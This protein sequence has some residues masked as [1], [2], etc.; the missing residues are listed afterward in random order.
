VLHL[1]A[2]LRSEAEGGEAA[3]S[4]FD[5][6]TGLIFWTL[7]I[8]GLLLAILAKWVWPALLRSVEERERKIARQLAEAEKMNAE[9]RTALEEHRQLLA[10]AKEE[11]QGLINEAKTVAAKERELL[12]EKAR[13]EQQ[14]M[15]DRAKREIDVE[16]ERAITQL[17][18][19]AVD[20]SLAAAAKLIEKRLD[21]ADDRKIVEQYLEALERNAR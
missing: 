4:P 15:L 13:A 17:R 16:R 2:A 10:G 14:Q 11:A 21:S 3:F 7:I 5:I 20:L 8:F 12:L 6:N 19:E 1:I 18:R 9:A